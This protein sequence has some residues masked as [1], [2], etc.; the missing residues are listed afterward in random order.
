MAP[1]SKNIQML[2]NKNSPAE[3]DTYSQAKQ[4][5]KKGRAVGAS[6]DYWRRSVG[7]SDN[8][9][10]NIV[11]RH[12]Q[13]DLWFTTDELKSFKQNCARSVHMIVRGN[14]RARQQNICERGLE[15][16]STAG[17]IQIRTRRRFAC[18]VVLDE[19]EEQRQAGVLVVDTET[20]ARVYQDVTARSAKSAIA[21][22]ESDA[23]GVQ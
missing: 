5:S 14:H 7:F 3:I 22:G 8:H 16:M 12:R 10:V 13:G 18:K 19:Q 15:D 11:S 9:D 1:F 21:R 20:M 23:K 6:Q 2:D 17:A 4:Q